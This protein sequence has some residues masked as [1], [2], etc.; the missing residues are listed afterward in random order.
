MVQDDHH[1]QPRFAAEGDVAAIEKLIPL[2]VRG[3]QQDCYSEAQ[4]DAAL[5]S[6]FAVDRQLI[7]D[8]TYYVVERDGMVLG[9]GGWSK[10]KSLY[11]GDGDRTTRDPELDPRIDAARVRAFFVHPNHARRGIGRSIMAE[12]ERAIRQ[13]GFTRVEIVATLIGEHLYAGFGYRV[14][15]RFEIFMKDGQTLP[16]VRMAKQ[17]G[18]PE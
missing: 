14:I 8:R 11:G 3:L 18:Q 17:M 13:N 6:V 16:V 10:R 5:G 1:W 9:C 15:E 7:Q 2:S 12:C 4:M